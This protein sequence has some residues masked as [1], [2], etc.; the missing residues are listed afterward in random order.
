VEYSKQ[1]RNKYPYF[2]QFL[3]DLDSICDFN[4]T[5]SYYYT[6]NKKPKGIFIE[7]KEY[8]DSYTPVIIEE[9]LVWDIK[10][11]VINVDNLKKYKS[12]D[13]TEYSF[14]QN[15]NYL[16]QA[17][18][19]YPYYGNYKW[20][21]DVISLLK[22]KNDCSNEDLEILARAYANIANNLVE[23]G[24]YGIFED[25]LE[26]KPDLNYKLTQSRLKDY[27][28]FVELSLTNYEIIKRRNSSFQSYLFAD[29]SLK[30]AHEYMHI[31]Y[32]LKN[33]GF[34]NL[35]LEFLKKVDYRPEYLHWAKS[36]LEKCDKN[37]F[38]FT[39]GD[40]DTYPLWYV[41]DFLNFRKDVKVINLSFLGSFQ[42]QNH[43]KDRNGLKLSFNLE[44]AY[45][46]NCGIIFF[47]GDKNSKYNLT[48]RTIQFFDKV[49]I[50]IENNGEVDISLPIEGTY[51]G[52]KINLFSDKYYLNLEELFIL[53]ILSNYPT[54][55]IYYTSY[56]NFPSR[57]YINNISV[58]E[59]SEESFLYSSKSIDLARKSL[60][61]V[62]LTPFKS[63]NY[64]LFSQTRELANYIKLYENEKFEDFIKEWMKQMPDTSL[65]NRNCIYEVANRYS[66][67]DIKSGMDIS[68]YPK[69]EMLKYLVKSIQG[70]TFSRETYIEDLY[71]LKAIINLKTV[72]ANFSVNASWTMI[73][74]ILLEKL[75]LNSVIQNQVIQKELKTCIFFL[76][77]D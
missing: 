45:D 16:I 67:I 21:D 57:G 43:I 20:Y 60:Q 42:H 29:I 27:L 44:K 22:D 25:S 14:S 55:K 41:Q 37:S 54:F 58:F 35:A 64:F 75:M 6:I 23:N 70:L 71:L 69:K 34:D 24:Q 74:D 7:I 31:Y 39:Y 51:N 62:N 13:S 50:S 17:M 4:L 30:V 3:S 68:L 63:Y 47:R 33:Y 8:N 53:D 2:K 56:Y 46:K 61:E 73:S 1:V 49:N 9:F 59:L 18:D 28:K 19:Y 32:T 10:Q 48:E 72:F 26:V 36:Y 52:K 5:N 76:K 38:L 11:K 12:D 65:I 66:M 77:N 15:F 40:S